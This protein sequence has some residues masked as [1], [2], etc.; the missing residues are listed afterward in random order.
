MAKRSKKKA[1][2]KMKTRVVYRNAKKTAPRR[3]RRQK[4]M[5]GTPAV[6]FGGAALAGAAGAG[7]ISAMDTPPALFT[8]G[9]R[10][11]PATGAGLL[12][13]LAGLFLLKGKSKGLAV[14]AG[15]GLMA[16]AAIAKGAGWG[17]DSTSSSADA[18][19]VYRTR[20]LTGPAVVT[21]PNRTLVAPEGRKVYA[22]NVLR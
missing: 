12:L 16:P 18:L 10:T 19:R 6:R 7:Y 21:Q 4:G 5:M 2:R 11:S 1:I 3:A 8:L 17:K 13:A 22:D 14:A 9:D 20:R 15:L